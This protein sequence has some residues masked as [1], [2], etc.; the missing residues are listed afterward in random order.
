V[1]YTA[2]RSNGGSRYGRRRSLR[3]RSSGSD[4]LRCDRPAWLLLDGDRGLDLRL[5][6]L[7][8][9][10][11]L[12]P[13]LQRL[14]LLLFLMT[15]VDRFPH[16]TAHGTPHILAAVVV[17]QNVPGTHAVRNQALLILAFRYVLPQAL[18]PRAVRRYRAPTVLVLTLGCVPQQQQSLLLVSQHL[19]PI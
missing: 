4:R 15:P 13:L 8:L 12:V 17:R 18:H 11:L 19:L 10:S 6:L 3:T 9:N 7:L 1:W 16:R 2:R 5:L 14:H